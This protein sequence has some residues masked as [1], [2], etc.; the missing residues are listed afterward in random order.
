[1]SSG[2]SA[3]EIAAV[4]IPG[5]FFYFLADRN[6]YEVHIRSLSTND[7]GVPYAA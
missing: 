4:L 2:A 6:E 5:F 1:M 7:R 3:I